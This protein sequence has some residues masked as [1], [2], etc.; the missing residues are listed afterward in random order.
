MAAISLR[1]RA[2]SPKSSTPSNAS[3]NSRITGRSATIGITGTAYPAPVFSTSYT[4]G[5]GLSPWQAAK[6]TIPPTTT[7]LMADKSPLFL[8]ITIQ[9]Y[10]S[11]S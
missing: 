5:T 3:G 4:K 1:R 6:A 11:Y 10:R 8:V 9:I 7:A 2:Q